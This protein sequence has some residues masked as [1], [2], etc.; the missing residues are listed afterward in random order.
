[1]NHEF[2][3]HKLNPEGMKKAKLIAEGFD[4]LVRQLD[5]LCIDGRELS[6]CRTKLEEACFFAKKAMAISLDNQ[7]WGPSISGP[8]AMSAPDEKY[9][10][11]QTARTERVL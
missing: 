4:S 11:N 3:V 1:M 7:D 8:M 2:A 5:V 6:V 10:P 9:N